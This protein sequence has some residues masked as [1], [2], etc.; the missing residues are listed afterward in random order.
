M[1][2]I[3]ILYPSI[4]MFFLTGCLI[5]SLGLSRFVAIKTNKVSIKYYT[6]YTE[7]EQPDRLHILGRHVQ[8]HFEVPPL[9]H[10]GVLLIFVTQTVT[11]VNLAAAWLFVAFRVVH[12]IIH[13][14]SNNVS[15]RFFCFG[16][17]LASLATL[18]I[19]LLTNLIAH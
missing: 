19:S 10:I 1:Q 16:L 8:N 4:A 11:E 18:W 7:G 12:T 2:E 6:K 3:S 9:F 13:L 5:L 14:S 15:Q 17:S